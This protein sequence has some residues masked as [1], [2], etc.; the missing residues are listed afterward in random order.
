MYSRKEMKINQDHVLN[1]YISLTFKTLMYQFAFTFGCVLLM[2]LS[3]SINI[4]V[5]SNALFLVTIG[6]ICVLSIC[7]IMIFFN[8][9]NKFNLCIFTFYE[10]MTI[11]GFVSMFEKD[12]IV[13]A[14]LLTIGICF[15]LGIYALT[16]KYNHTNLIGMLFAG[17]SC[18]S[19]ISFTNLFLGLEWLHI[20]ELYAGILLFFGYIVVDIQYF[21]KKNI[22]EKRCIHDNLHIVAAMNIYMDVI[23]IF[24]R[25]LIILTKNKKKKKKD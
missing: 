16:T 10:I 22:L 15:A 23:N 21:L 20:F 17:L 19:I 13:L 4:F 14:L 1:N 3:E 18:L 24:I 5:R 6:S 9:I 8:Q 25:I 7:I 11:C 12:I 2:V